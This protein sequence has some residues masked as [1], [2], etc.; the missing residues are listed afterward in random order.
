MLILSA[1]INE[2]RSA[3]RPLVAAEALDQSSQMLYIS[4][5]SFDGS[6]ES[7][8]ILIS[9]TIAEKGMRSLAVMHNT[10]GAAPV[11]CPLGSTY[12]YL[13]PLLLGLLTT[14]SA[15]IPPYDESSQRV[16]QT[17]VHTSGRCPTGYGSHC[18]RS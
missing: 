14:I 13:T 18:N 15:C 17:T 3:Y 16:P 8:V 5:V 2:L 1:R 6:V 12:L 10:G 11:A 4:E 9:T 7:G